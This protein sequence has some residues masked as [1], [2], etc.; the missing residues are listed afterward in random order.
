MIKTFKSKGLAELWREGQ[1]KRIDARLHDHI[2][3]RLDSLDMAEQAQDMNVPGF[4]FHILRGSRPKR[5]AVHVNG[6]G[7]SHSRLRT[8]MRIVSILRTITN[9]VA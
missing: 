9:E 5:Y 8:G 1:T 2:L 7:A 4:N 6:H 3:R